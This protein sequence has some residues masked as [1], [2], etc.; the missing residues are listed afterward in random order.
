[1]FVKDI[2]PKQGNPRNSEGAFYQ[3]ADGE[4]IFVYS[5]FRGDSARDYTYADIMTIRSGDSGETWSAPKLVSSA[6]DYHAMN[7]MSVSLL[8]MENGDIGLFYLVRMNWVDMYIVL[9]RSSDQGK[10]WSTPT[11][12]STRKGYYVLNNDRVVRTSSGR[13][14]LPVAEHKNTVDE[15]GNVKFAPANTIFFFSDDDGISW[16]EADTN[17]TLSIPASHSGLQEPGIVE[18]QPG[19]LYG[20]ART[21]LGRQYEFFSD[22]DGDHW[23]EA[24]P[25]RFT[26]PLSPL[27][28][29]KLSTGELVAVWNPIPPNNISVENRA[30]G[31][32]TPLVCSISAD[33]GKTWSTPMII[34]NDSDCGYCYTSIW[35]MGN[36]LLLAYCAGSEKD[37][38]SCLN[39]LRIRKLAISRRIDRENNQQH[40]M[41]IGFS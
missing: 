10:T 6:E 30:T 33:Y 24:V 32:R 17:L 8:H 25:S 7:V 9:Q 39:R 18:L 14:I 2:A 20:W 37:L 21:D 22:D 23:S 31:N 16:R 28:M 41:G 1:M 5:A 15:D 36:C 29:K 4:C 12:C 38:G 26:S 3:T 34:E 27:S 40:C 11:K 19:H 13:I 35:E